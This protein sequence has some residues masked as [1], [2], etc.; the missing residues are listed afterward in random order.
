V[1]MHRIIPGVYSVRGLPLGRVYVIEDPDGLTV[2]DTSLV[3]APYQLGR[4]LAALGRSIGDIRRILITHAHPDHIGGLRALK[5]LTGAEVVASEVEQPVIEG[6]MPIPRKPLK[7]LSR[8]DRLLRPPRITLR[9][10][11]VDRPVRH[12]EVLSDVLGGLQ[13]IATPGHTPGH[14]SFWQ[15]ALGIV[16]CGDVIAAARGMRLPSHDWTVDMAEN[17]RSV[18]KLADLNARIVCFGHGAP[19]THNTARLIA[20]FARKVDDGR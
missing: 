9:G 17:R 1:K 18:R 20:D 19:L 15:P 6:K 10:T 11:P 12:G 7:G 13:V 14:V 5:A 16:F 4:Q 3:L 8:R 2:I